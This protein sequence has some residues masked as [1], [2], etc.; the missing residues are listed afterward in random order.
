MDD[1]ASFN[2]LLQF[3]RDGGG[4]VLQGDDISWAH[5]KAFSLE[6]LTGLE[7]RDN[8]TSHCGQSID[9]GRGGSYAVSFEAAAHGLIAGL[10]GQSFLYGDDIDTTRVA[11]S[12]VGGGRV[13][14][15]ATATTAGVANC[16]PK[17]VIVAYTPAQTE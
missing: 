1:V 8:G 10:E 15:L 17:P 3:S 5:G 6:P 11:E 9:N 7:H 14:V 2:A 13:E 16:E 4:V 12:P